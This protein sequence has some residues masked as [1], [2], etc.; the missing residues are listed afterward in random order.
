MTKAQAEAALQIPINIV[1][2]SG[3]DFVDAILDPEAAKMQTAE[4]GSYEPAMKD[5]T[6]QKTE[7]FFKRNNCEDTKQL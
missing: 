3:Y 6:F 7:R 4:H 1:K 2:S 5:L